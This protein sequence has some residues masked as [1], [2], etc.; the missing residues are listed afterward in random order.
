MAAESLRGRL[1]NLLGRHRQMGDFMNRSDF[2]LGVCGTAPA[3]LSA[4]R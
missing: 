4:T 2:A 1:T 3:A